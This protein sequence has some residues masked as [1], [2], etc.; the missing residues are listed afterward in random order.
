MLDTG[1]VLAGCA[2]CATFA[3]D[4]VTGRVRPTC[5]RTEA[6]AMAGEKP[7]GDQSDE[8]LMPSQV[9]RRFHV[10]P[11]TVTRWTRAGKLNPIP[12]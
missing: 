9:V 3:I 1:E 7:P 5:T 8:L 10:D 12:T 4:R 11:K 2:G 6:H